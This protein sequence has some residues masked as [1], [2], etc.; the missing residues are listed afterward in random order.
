MFGRL[1]DELINKIL[2]YNYVKPNYLR[3]MKLVGKLLNKC[4]ELK[5]MEADPSIDEYDDQMDDFEYF[6][7]YF[8][9]Y[10]HLFFGHKLDKIVGLEYDDDPLY[11]KER[12]ALNIDRRNWFWSQPDPIALL[13]FEF[14][15]RF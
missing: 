1:P 14:N 13:I 8:P 9:N 4:D 2:S 5:I 3:E 12:R 10:T 6:L 7:D 15:T 11:I